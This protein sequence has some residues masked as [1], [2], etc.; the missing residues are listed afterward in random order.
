M[1]SKWDDIKI[2]T[3]SLINHTECIVTTK[4]AS[5]SAGETTE[6]KLKHLAK[7]LLEF[8]QPPPESSARPHASKEGSEERRQNRPR[9]P[10]RL[11]TFCAKCSEERDERGRGK[12]GRARARPIIIGRGEGGI[13]L[14]DSYL[15]IW[16]GAWMFKELQASKCDSFKPPSGVPVVDK[17]QGWG[18]YF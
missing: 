17:I 9:T 12:G 8:T 18:R 3:V 13:S 15:V 5:A 14:D 10:K 16:I 6:C 4:Q 1:C 2:S 7:S 11:E